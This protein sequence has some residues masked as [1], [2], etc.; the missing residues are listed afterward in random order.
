MM[1]PMLLHTTIAAAM[2]AYMALLILPEPLSKAVA[3]SLTL[4]M[5][6]YLGWDTFWSIIGGWRK[7]TAESEA[8]RMLPL[9]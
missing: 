6:A 4:Y 3:V 1:N 7:L 2:T 5:V 8:A 9:H